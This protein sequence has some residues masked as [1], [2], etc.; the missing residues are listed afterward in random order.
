MTKD[1][2]GYGYVDDDTPELSIAVLPQHRGRGIGTQLLTDLLREAQTRYKAVSLS[3][4]ADNPAPEMYERA[5]FEVVTKE[6]ASLTMIKELRATPHEDVKTSLAIDSSSNR[7]HGDDEP[8]IQI[9]RSYE[10]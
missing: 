8:K 2:A 6:A 7:E 9:G 1:N 3:V 10:Y 4:S 5:G